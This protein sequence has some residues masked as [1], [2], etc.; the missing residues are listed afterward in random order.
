[1]GDA[2]AH[3]R[4]E[5]EKMKSQKLQHLFLGIAGFD[6]TGKSGIVKDAFDKA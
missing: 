2:F 4:V 1:M 6:G 3:L 5:R